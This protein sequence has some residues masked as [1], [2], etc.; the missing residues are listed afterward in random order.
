MDCEIIKRVKLLAVLQSPLWKFGT[1]LI[2]LPLRSGGEGKR[3]WRIALR[4]SVGALNLGLPC[5][6]TELPIF[7]TD[8]LMTNVVRS[9][10]G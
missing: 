6:T 10:T 4:Q 3:V 1:A 9:E 5:G 7:P 2:L 8:L